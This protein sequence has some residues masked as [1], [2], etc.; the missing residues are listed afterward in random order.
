MSREI[1][2]WA[3]WRVPDAPMRMGHLRSTP[4]RGKEVFAFSYDQAWFD[5]GHSRQLDPDFAFFQIRRSR[6]CSTPNHRLQI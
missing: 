6:T 5:A 1:E 2:V 3:D 4:S